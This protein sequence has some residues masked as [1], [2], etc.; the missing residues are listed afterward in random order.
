MKT[1]SIF[2]L[3]LVLS[4][5]G[6]YA[7]Q[8]MTDKDMEGLKGP[9][10]SV[11]TSSQ[12][13]LKTGQGV[14]LSEP[15]KATITHYDSSGRMK[16][17]YY[18]FYNV[19]FVYESIDGFKVMRQNEVF[20]PREGFGIAMTKPDDVVPIETNEVLT[21]PDHRFHFKYVYEYDGKGRIISELQYFNNNQLFKSAIYE[22]DANSLLILKK[23]N[24]LKV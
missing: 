2:I 17:N 19:G 5:M 1:I 8:K 16:S 13:I 18:A 10:K 7:Q 11:E 9:V 6:G 14:K 15:S 3:T 12:S 22:Y 23:I 21:E 20:E 24:R 4:T